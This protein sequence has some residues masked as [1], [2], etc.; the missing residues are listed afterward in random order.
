MR[1][2]C[3]FGV[4]DSMPGVCYGPALPIIGLVTSIAGAGLSFFGQMQAAQTQ[5][6]M[7]RYQA[8][9]AAITAKQEATQAD[10]QRSMADQNA[11]MADA[12][13]DTS[14][15]AGDQAVLTQRQKVANLVGRQEATLASNGVEVNNGSALDLTSD[16]KT[17]GNIDALNLQHNYDLQTQNFQTQ[18]GN[19]RRQA[20]LALSNKQYYEANASSASSLA[21]S[22]AFN[23]SPLTGVGSLLSSAGSV[24]GQWYQF[25]KAS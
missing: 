23:V 21:N 3:S 9:Q 11:K 1:F 16:T 18:A 5:A 20:S 12:A 25:S 2:G 8:Q 14:R 7:A 19:Y 15:T 6:A 17:Q 4:Q 24:A 22:G 13:A 10:Y